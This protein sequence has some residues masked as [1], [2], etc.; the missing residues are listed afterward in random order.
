M[1]DDSGLVASKSHRHVEA[2][3]W[4]HF[5]SSLVIAG[6][7]GSGSPAALSATALDGSEASSAMRGLFRNKLSADRAA[8]AR[9]SNLATIRPIG[10]EVSW[11][12]PATKR[13]EVR[14][15][16]RI[17]GRASV[18]P[19]IGAADLNE[20]SVSSVLAENS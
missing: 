15:V 4:C 20:K 2:A 6:M 13:Y 5:D 7:E 17:A 3:T 8:A 10:G 14:V 19:L 18:K 16:K 11:W 1:V 9:L 12:N